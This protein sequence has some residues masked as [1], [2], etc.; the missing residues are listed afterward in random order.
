MADNVV[1]AIWNHARPSVVV[2]AGDTIVAG[3]LWAS[4]VLFELLANL[5]PVA[6]WAGSFIEN[7]HAAGVVA[8]FGILAALL[9][10]DIARLKRK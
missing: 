1:V 10:V 9:V 6:G 5:V 8:T 2:I 7:L 3:T 4:L